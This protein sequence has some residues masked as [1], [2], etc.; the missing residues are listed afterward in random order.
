[1]S[2]RARRLSRTDNNL[3]AASRV[4]G[5]DGKHLRASARRRRPR[6]RS[7]TS[8]RAI[9]DTSA[10][11]LAELGR[12]VALAGSAGMHRALFC[13]PFAACVL[14]PDDSPTISVAL[15]SDQVQ[16]QLQ[17]G[18]QHDFAGLAG[19]IDGMPFA[20]FVAQSDQASALATFTLPRAGITG[21]DARIEL[22]EGSQVFTVDFPDLLAERT[23]HLIADT[24]VEGGSEVDVDDGVAADVLT[25]SAFAMQ[26]TR[27]CLT[28]S[29]QMTDPGTA[30]ISLPDDLAS[31]WTCDG[32]SGSIVSGTLAV[33]VSATV[34]PASCEGPD[35]TCAPATT[36]AR[37]AWLPVTIEL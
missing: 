2:P 23:I 5:V 29:M 26:G 37:T 32:S 8:A 35:L 20:A 27:T 10:R 22:V 12:G 19:S 16:V 4:S 6:R 31:E 33:T 36:P 7:L 34:A 28:S 14:P 1:V 15:T 30:I 3:S 25:A 17:R 11:L 21:A 9:F 18:P 13:L 24:W